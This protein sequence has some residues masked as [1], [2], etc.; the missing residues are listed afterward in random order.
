MAKYTPVRR[1]RPRPLTVKELSAEQRKSLKYSATLHKDT[2]IEEWNRRAALLRAHGDDTV[3]S[4]EDLRQQVMLAD[5]I[6]EELFADE[7]DMTPAK[8]SEIATRV[9]KQHQRN[10]MSKRRRNPLLQWLETRNGAIALGAAVAG[11]TGLAI[12]GYHRRGK[13]KALAAG[14]QSTVTGAGGSVVSDPAAG[15]PSPKPVSKATLPSE[16]LKGGIPLEPGWKTVAWYTYPSGQR[17]IRIDEYGDAL[18]K[19]GETTFT[20]H[21]ATIIGHWRWVVIA[22]E[23]TWLATGDLEGTYHLARNV[24]YNEYDRESAEDTMQW[25]AAMEAAR[26]IDTAY[27]LS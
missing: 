8:A 25:A 26:W 7:T 17:W 16:I 24:I 22:G 19:E 10:P 4:G 14:K 21:T 6:L 1:R 23:A 18:F 27:G 3:Q 20:Q 5:A 15:G 13:A 11:F 2:P 9:R 12:Y